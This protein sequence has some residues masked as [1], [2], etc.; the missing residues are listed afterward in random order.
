MVFTTQ[1][2]YLNKIH[3]KVNISQ[4]SSCCCITNTSL[5]LVHDYLVLPDTIRFCICSFQWGA[6]KAVIITCTSLK[7]QL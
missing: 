4:M 5:T 2:I 6:V 3:Y 1:N 7:V